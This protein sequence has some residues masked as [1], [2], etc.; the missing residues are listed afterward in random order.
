MSLK[1][2]G[3]WCFAFV[4]AHAA[5]LLLLLIVLLIVQT[6][7]LFLARS[8]ARRRVLQHQRLGERGERLARRVL[9]RAGYEISAEQVTGSYEVAVDGSPVPVYVRADFLA[10]KRGKTYL[11]EVKSGEVSVKITGRA[12]RRQLLEYLVAF[13]VAGLLL[14]DMQAEVVRLVEFPRLTQG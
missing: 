12:T 2:L 4:E 13:D 10:T 6:I 1:D 14:V 5:L 8:L 11:A 9:E 3:E 7:R